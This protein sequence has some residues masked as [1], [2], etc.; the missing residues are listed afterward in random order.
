MMVVLCESV[1]M[2]SAPILL[3]PR[4]SD[5]MV[6]SREILLTSSVTTRLCCR[7]HAMNCCVLQTNNVVI[8]DSSSHVGDNRILTIGKWRLQ[9]EDRLQQIV[10]TSTQTRRLASQAIDPCQAT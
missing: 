4:L 6:V 10:L 8:A 7:L 3:D 5:V 2:S 1:L 9:E